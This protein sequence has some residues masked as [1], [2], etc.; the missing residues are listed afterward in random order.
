MSAKRGGTTEQNRVQHFKVQ[1]GEPLLA[2]LE[3]ALPCCADDIG[4]LDRRPR[5][6][7]RTTAVLAIF[8]QWQ[9]VQRTGGRVQ[10]LLRK[11]EIDSGLFQIAMTQ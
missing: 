10:V 3:E 7:L 2:V 1:P 6:L 8:G 4:H 9:R 5:H 11:V